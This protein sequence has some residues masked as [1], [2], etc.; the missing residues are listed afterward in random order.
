MLVFSQN[1]IQ[2]EGNKLFWIIVI[3]LALPILYYLLFHKLLRTKITIPDWRVLWRRPLKI[4][5]TKDRQYR[6]NVLTLKVSNRSRKDIDLEA[7]ILYFRK[8]WVKRKFKLKGVD[9]Y[10][11][12]PLYL[13]AGKTHE[14][15]IDLSVFF[16]YDR[17]LKRY[18]WAKVRVTDTRGRK[19]SSR[20]V[21]L[22]KSLFS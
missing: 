19:Y 9:R 5:L 1:E 22:R 8:L 17:T 21:T 14:L 12:Y 11:I 2:P 20:Y 3:L 7:P 10:E 4:E 15:R 16:N 13:E 6:P 18:L